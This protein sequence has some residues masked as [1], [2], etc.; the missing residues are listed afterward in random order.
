MQILTLELT[1]VDTEQESTGKIL[2]QLKADLDTDNKLEAELDD[3]FDVDE[4]KISTCAPYLVN[5]MSC[6]GRGTP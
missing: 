6:L 2:N 4:E 3:E 5:H 1:K